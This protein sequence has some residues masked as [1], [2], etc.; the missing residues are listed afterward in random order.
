M[1]SKGR[2]R[3]NRVAGHS[4]PGVELGYPYPRLILPR[5]ERAPSKNGKR[6]VARRGE[7]RWH[8]PVRRALNILASL[9]LIVVSAPIM[10]LIAIAVKLSSPGPVFYKQERVGIDRRQDRPGD[11]PHPRRKRDLGGRIFEIYKFRTMTHRPERNS[12]QVWADAD[13][14]RVTAVGRILRTYRLDELPQ[15][16]NV[17]RGD[18]NLVGPRPEQPEIF[19][20]LR[21]EVQDYQL[22]Q[23][24]LPGITG[25]AQVHLKYDQCLDDVRR[26]VQLD[27]HYV[28]RESPIED[29]RIMA[30]TVPVVL[31]GKGSQ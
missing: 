18:M 9:V 28:D 21:E 10:V 7:A 30:R 15:L 5:S 31:F 19:Q 12:E 17:L 23:R 26:K 8:R 25:L 14:P 11:P 29:L 6:T 3:R 16:F 1:A 2:S 24:V 13:D 20:A 4:Q 22:R 27:L